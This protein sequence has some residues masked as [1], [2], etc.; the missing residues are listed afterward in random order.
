[1]ITFLM[2]ANNHEITR[3]ADQVYKLV[4]TDFSQGE[5]SA[6]ILA[7]SG[8]FSQELVNSICEGIEN[9]MLSAQ[10]KKGL[11]KRMFSIL[12]EGL[13][14]L[15]IHGRNDETGE[16]YGHLVVAKTKEA[17]LVSFGSYA[18]VEDQKFLTTHIDKLNSF[19]QEEVKEFYLQKLS[20]G[21]LSEKGGAGLG[22]ITIAMKSKNKM[23][24]NFSPTDDSKLLYFEI[25]AQLDIEGE[26]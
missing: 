6:L 2:G 16:K 15:R 26:G 14:N 8:K 10:V 5:E 19:S 20:N 3:A 22:F 25:N 11:V 23:A 12:I 21:F 18:S 9:M 17:Y 7:H 13:Q 24:Y 1:M 4:Q